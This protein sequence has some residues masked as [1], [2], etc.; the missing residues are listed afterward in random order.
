VNPFSK[1]PFGTASQKNKE[2]GLKHL[3]NPYQTDPKSHELKK[4]RKNKGEKERRK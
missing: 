2:T 4:Q 3:K 1:N